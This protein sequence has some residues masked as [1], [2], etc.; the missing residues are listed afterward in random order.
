MAEIYEKGQVAL[1]KHMREALKMYPGTKVIFQ[2]ED[3]GILVKKADDWAAEF[4]ELCAGADMSDEQTEKF[5][6]KMEKKRLKEMQNVP[7]L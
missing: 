4:D 7:G 5:I 3:R 1:P 6:A 2:M